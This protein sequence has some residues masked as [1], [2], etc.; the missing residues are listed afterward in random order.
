[1]KRELVFELIY[2][3]NSLER[4]SATSS[5]LASVISQTLALT[6]RKFEIHFVL[7]SCNLKSDDLDRKWPIS[8]S[9]LHNYTLEVLCCDWLRS[10]SLEKY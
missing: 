4:P 9:I 7:F 8:E 6:I 10:F 5:I 1:M 2:T 3:E